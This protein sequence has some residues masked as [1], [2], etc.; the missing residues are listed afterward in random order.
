MPDDPRHGTRFAVYLCP[1]AESEYYR[2]GSEVLGYDVRARRD[3][4]LPADV[5]PEWQDQAGPYG[6]HLTLLEGFYCLPESLPAIES[7]L[8]ATVACLSPD[9]DLSLH[10]GQVVRA[11][12]L[13][14]RSV[15]QIFRPSP[16]LLMLHALLSARLARFVSHSNFS[17][18]LDAHPDRYAAP[19]ERARMRLIHTPRGL[20]TYEPHYTLLDPFGGTEEE[21]E[22]LRRR[23]EALLAPYTEQ[24]YRSVALFVKPEGEVRWQLWADVQMN[25]AVPARPIA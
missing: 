22:A 15:A 3:V 4:P 18:L 1:P 20:D 11:T 19:W 23:L 2:R 10:E 16:H 21:G 5:R 17:D 12:T 13:H 8:R 14:D 24:T 7:E 9:A 25:A 6:F